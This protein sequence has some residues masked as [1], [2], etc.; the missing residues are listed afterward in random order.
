M[1]FVTQAPGIYPMLTIWRTPSE[2]HARLSACSWLAALS[3]EVPDG[4]H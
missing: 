3:T 2:Q 1:I 4:R